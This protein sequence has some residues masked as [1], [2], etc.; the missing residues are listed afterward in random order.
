ML[1]LNK[2][3]NYCA[4]FHNYVHSNNFENHV[5]HVFL[6]ETCPSG[7]FGFTYKIVESFSIVE[8]YIIALYCEFYT[9]IN[10]CER[11]RKNQIS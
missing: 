4:S 7:F 1:K 10:F 9:L 8:I 11:Q 3:S 2:Y 5:I 6:K